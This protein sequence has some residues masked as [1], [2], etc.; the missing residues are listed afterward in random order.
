[1][2]LDLTKI[3][4]LLKD[5]DDFAKRFEAARERLRVEWAKPLLCPVCPELCAETARLRAEGDRMEGKIRN[6]LLIADSP[7]FGQY[8]DDMEDVLGL[9]R[10][11][12]A[13]D[14]TVGDD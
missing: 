2:K 7:G 5:L 9:L 6:A 3:E 13:D 11:G 10:G 1:M 4:T 14:P 8:D 12:L